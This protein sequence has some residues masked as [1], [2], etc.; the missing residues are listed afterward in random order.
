MKQQMCQKQKSRLPKFQINFFLWKNRAAIAEVT[1][2]LS[3]CMYMHMFMYYMAA[4]KVNWEKCPVIES[5]LRLIQGCL[6]SHVYRE[7]INDSLPNYQ[8]G[9]HVHWLQQHSLFSLRIW[10][11]G[12]RL[13]LVN[14]QAM[15]P[16]AASGLLQKAKNAKTW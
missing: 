5:A 15:P 10:M 8:A 16:Q 14:T 7:I 6:E 3:F 1:S 2:V 13:C 4:S 9:F 12:Q 11:L